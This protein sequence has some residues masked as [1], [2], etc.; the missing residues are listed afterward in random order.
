MN[1]LTFPRFINLGYLL[2]AILA[3]SGT[4]RSQGVDRVE[5]ERLKSILSNIKNEVKKNYY[6]PSYHGIDLD[7][8]FKK[9]D[10]R[11]DQVTST[12]QGF[13]VIAQVLI[14]FDDSHLYF[15]PP[16]TNLEVEYGWRMQAFGNKV[17][18]TQVRPKSDADA[19]GLK[20][21]DEVIAVSGFHPSR[22]ELW[23]VL[24]YYGVLSK[25]DK[26]VLT[27]KSSG[28]QEA[29]DL[30][31][32]AQMDKQPQN[33]TFLNYFQFY[34]PFYNEDNY[35]DRSWTLGDV[36]IW[37]MPSFVIEPDDAESILD[38]TKRDGTLILDL[39][40]NGGG[41][42]KTMEKMVGNFFTKDVKI[43]DLK[44]RKPK[45][46]SIAKTRG[47]GGFSGKLI[48]LID[49]G[50]GSAS[51]IFARVIQLEKRGTIL[52]DVSAGAVML[53][54]EYQGDVGSS[55]SV[56]FAVSITDADLIMA[57]GASLEHIGVTPDQLIVPTAADL[58][59]GRDPVLDR[60]LEISGVKMAADE[61]AKYH[62]Y[63][64]K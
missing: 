5:R 61:Y 48:V 41:Y 64:W 12:S 11:L 36:M 34:D 53:A 29:R 9:A 37:K 35:K 4:G 17:F 40:G 52:G 15:N 55:T 27:V 32:K 49:S 26:L 8:R 23:K 38:R 47:K 18:I 42:A 28:A 20:V 31:I 59:A 1:I 16:A 10:E 13:G 60:A 44:G 19:K 54:R 56:P 39:R 6:D 3:F 46:P 57:D 24:Y 22:K 14:D 33:I 25:R 43:A 2:L 50:S 62:K 21:G 51:E 45:D 30:D 58:A 63:Y 7:A